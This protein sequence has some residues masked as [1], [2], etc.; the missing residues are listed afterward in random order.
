MKAA[1]FPSIKLQLN[2]HL[3]IFACGGLGTHCSLGIPCCNAS[4]IRCLMLAGR[5]RGHL[6]YYDLHPSQGS[7]PRITHAR[8]L[9]PTIKPFSRCSTERDCLLMSQVLTLQLVI[10]TPIKPLHPFTSCAP[11]LRGPWL[12]PW[13]TSP[14]RVSLLKHLGMGLLWNHPS[15][16]LAHV[17]SSAAARTAYGVQVGGFPLRLILN[18]FLEEVLQKPWEILNWKRAL[19]IIHLP[20]CAPL[21]FGREGTCYNGTRTPHPQESCKA[22]H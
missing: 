1:E 12:L 21:S 4:C 8:C 15:R 2:T 7:E 10:S 6:S 16:S 13:A 17:V 9:P 3:S 11:L 5:C 20:S 18:F 14:L 22:R 19:L